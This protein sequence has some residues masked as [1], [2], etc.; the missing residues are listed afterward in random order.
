MFEHQNAKTQLMIVCEDKLREYANYLI[1]LVGQKDDTENQIVGVKDGTVTAAIYSPKQYN[2]T[3]PKITSNTHILFLGNFKEA[4]EHWKNVDFKFDKYGMKY[5]WL[6]KRAVM[7]VDEIM[8]KKKD[9]EKFISFAETYKR[10]FEKVNVNMAKSFPEI[11]K[12]MAMFSP[13]AFPVA[14]YGM[15]TGKIV[16]K[17]IWEQQYRCLTLVLYFDGLQEFLEE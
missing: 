15:I 2:D 7:Y 17:K 10:K 9:Y 13:I 11:A 8:V 1:A 12:W 4:K 6:G 5:G 3:L 14:I 16:R